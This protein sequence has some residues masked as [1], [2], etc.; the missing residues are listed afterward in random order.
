MAKDFMDLART[1]MSREGLARAVKRRDQLRRRML[2][3]E[4]R[5]ALGLRQKH[6]ARSS[7][8]KPP[9]L[10]RL[11]RQ[12]DMQIATARKVVR[13]MGGKLEIVARFHDAAVTI[14]LPPAPTSSRKSVTPTRLGPA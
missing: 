13:A 3:R 12:S 14:R 11:E 7:G 1:Q 4:L 5:Q 10:A 8:I 2:L 9:N 6:V